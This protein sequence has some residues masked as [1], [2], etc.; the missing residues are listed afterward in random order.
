[1]GTNTNLPTEIWLVILSLLGNDDEG[2]IHR[3][4]MRLVS[5]DFLKVLLPCNHGKWNIR[6]SIVSYCIDA[7]KYEA[8]QIF[9]IDEWVWRRVPDI[10]PKVLKRLNKYNM[11][12]PF[13]VQVL[14][15]N[16]HLHKFVWYDVRQ[17]WFMSQNAARIVR[18]DLIPDE[19]IVDLVRGKRTMRFHDD[20][21]DKM[22]CFISRYMS[23]PQY[24]TQLKL[25]DTSLSVEGF[26]TLAKALP[27]TIVDLNISCHIS[28]H[29]D[30]GY[31]L[32]D[33]PNSVIRAAGVRHYNAVR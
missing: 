22:V 32:E 33:L 10:K 8:M 19:P 31:I 18:F 20:R 30:D 11:K 2:F 23:F 4:K 12:L 26:T 15:W 25:K 6:E 29:E 1:M 13:T 14:H 3:V 21:Y 27:P 28:G 24:L 9:D 5:R 7:F 17:R 16:P